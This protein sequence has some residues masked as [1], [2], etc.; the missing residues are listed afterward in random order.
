MVLGVFLITIC[1]PFLKKEKVFSYLGLGFYFHLGCMGVGGSTFWEL[2]GLV[3]D[4]FPRR[5]WLV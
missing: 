1:N 5:S 2:L 3:F 4:S